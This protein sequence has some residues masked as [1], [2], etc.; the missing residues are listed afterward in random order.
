MFV[1]SQAAG[2]P[3]TGLQVMYLVSSK[4]LSA[5]GSACAKQGTIM[6]NKI[7][8]SVPKKHMRE[9]AMELLT[10]EICLNLDA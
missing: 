7:H 8:I 2:R 9:S 5:G 1:H 10:L 6:A 3:S 4:H